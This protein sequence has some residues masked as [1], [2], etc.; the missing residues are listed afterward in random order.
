[1]KFTGIKL[2]ELWMGFVMAF[3]WFSVYAEESLV[4]IPPNNDQ[5]KGRIEETKGKMKE[6]TG[7]ILDDKGMQIEGNVQKN[8]GK[9]QKGYGDLKQEIKKDQ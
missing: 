3:C 2:A 7:V 6:A 9:A 1:M 5:V 4:P 8:L